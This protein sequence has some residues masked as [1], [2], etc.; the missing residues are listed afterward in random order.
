MTHSAAPAVAEVNTAF[1]KSNM[2]FSKSRL[3]VGFR[4]WDSSLRT[5]GPLGICDAAVPFTYLIGDTPGSL[6]ISDWAA[7]GERM[8]P[9]LSRSTELAPM[10]AKVDKNFKVDEG[11]VTFDAEGNDNP[12][13]I[14]FSRH[15]HHPSAESGITIGRGYDMKERT[16]KEIVKGLTGA[17]LSQTAAEAFAKGAGLKGPEADKFVEENRGKLGHI[18]PEVQKNSLSRSTRRIGRMRSGSMTNG[19]LG[20]LPWSPGRT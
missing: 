1:H 18:S 4:P 6:G 19:R 16:E 7:P 14:F 17:G 15:L 10:P 11:Q 8:C 2:A 9:L 13:S 12:Q 5:C 3:T 20:I